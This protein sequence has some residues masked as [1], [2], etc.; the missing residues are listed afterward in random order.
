MECKLRGK[1]FK[2]FIFKNW[3]IAVAKLE[4][5]SRTYLA[6]YK[7][8]FGLEN[9]CLRFYWEPSGLEKLFSQSISAHFRVFFRWIL[10]GWESI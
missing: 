3:I 6:E 2:N 8:D 4:N 7:L 9:Y 5:W 10:N 1:R